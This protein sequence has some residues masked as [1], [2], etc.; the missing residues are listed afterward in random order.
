M[1]ATVLEGGAV[2]QLYYPNYSTFLGTAQTLPKGG[3]TRFNISTQSE[4][5]FRYGY[6]YF[7]GSRQRHT[8]STYIRAG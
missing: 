6:I 2:F 7:P 3:T 5:I 8:T 1:A 4:S